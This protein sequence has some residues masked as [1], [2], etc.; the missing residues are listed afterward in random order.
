MNTYLLKTRTR[1]LVRHPT[2]ALRLYRGEAQ[3]SREHLRIEL[4][5]AKS[6]AETCAKQEKGLVETV[7]IF[8]KRLCYINGYLYAACRSVKPKVVVETGVR[9]G[10]STAFILQALKDIKTGRLYSVDLPNVIVDGDVSNVLPR[11]L[12]T[13]GQVPD[14]LKGKMDAH[15]RGFEN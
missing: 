7:Q 8:Q 10:V 9:R 15:P 12:A 2:L 11:E 13:G 5:L 6:L 4:G 14:D 1:V 3:V